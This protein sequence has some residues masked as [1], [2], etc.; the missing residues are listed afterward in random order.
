MSQ[1]YSWLVRT[2]AGGA[3]RQ[4]V[5]QKIAEA[6]FPSLRTMLF[7]ELVQRIDEVRGIGLYAKL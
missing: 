1:M 6:S 7:A 2:K 5:R 3:G 4:N